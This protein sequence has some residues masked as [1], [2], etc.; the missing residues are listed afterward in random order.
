MGEDEGR[1]GGGGGGTPRKMRREKR[2]NY[3]EKA[4]TWPREDNSVRGYFFKLI[5]VTAERQPFRGIQV[6]V[7][8]CVSVIPASEGSSG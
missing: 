2:G 7:C 6:R 3:G 8:R 4:A 5:S 1:G